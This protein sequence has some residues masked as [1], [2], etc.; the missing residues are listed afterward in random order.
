MKSSSRTPVTQEQRDQI[1]ELHEMGYG[2]RRIGNKVGLG[3]KVVRSLLEQMG[4]LKR[5]KR[6]S[7]AV[8]PANKLDP[9]RDRI[10]EKVDK[11]LTTTRIL[12]EIREAGYTGSRTILATYVRQIRTR[13]S[14]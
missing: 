7:T 14:G 1:K 11:D 9:F 13:P 8:K 5:N 4:M 10:R 12:R 3:R 6:A 2:T